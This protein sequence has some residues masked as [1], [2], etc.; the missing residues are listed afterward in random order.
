MFTIAQLI[1]VH[2]D[3][4]SWL[5]FRGQFKVTN[6]KIAYIFLCARLA[7]GYYEILLGSWYRPF[8]IGKKFDLW[9]DLEEVISRSRKWKWP[10][11]SKRLLLGPGCRQTK[12]FTIA[13]LVKVRHD[14]WP[15]MTFWGHLKVMN[16]RIAYIFLM[17]RDRHMVP[18]EH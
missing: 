18:M 9:Y 3:L 2:L 5:I 1:K 13:D 10:V 15:W 4:W 6:V 8:R 7:Y 14:L 17:V 16:V 12:L 11:P